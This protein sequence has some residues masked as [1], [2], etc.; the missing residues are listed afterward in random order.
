MAI[1]FTA[2]KCPECG[3]EFDIEE[4]RKQAFCSYC[5]TRILINNDNEHIYRTID[6]AEIK[7]AEAE[8]IIRMR[9]LDLLEKE[10]EQAEKQ[11]SMKVKASIALAVLGT[12]MLCLGFMD[13]LGS[14]AGPEAYVFMTVG[15][16]MFLAVAFIWNI[17]RMR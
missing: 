7:K 9:E 4:G 16:I 10:R 14:S 5:G 17:H 13:G 12:L 3:A 8:Q 2:V 6:E 11:R 1:R 15:L